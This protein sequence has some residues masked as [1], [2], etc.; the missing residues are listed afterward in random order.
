[1][2]RVS[3]SALVSVSGSIRLAGCAGA[4]IERS[5]L[6]GLVMLAV[7][8]VMCLAAN[9]YL[10]VTHVDAPGLPRYG[11]T[12]AIHNPF[13]WMFVC[14]FGQAVSHAAEPHLPPRVNGTTEW[15]PLADFIKG[16]TTYGSSR[17]P[18]FERGVRLLAQVFFGTFDEWLA[19]PRLPPVYVLESMWALGYQPA[20]RREIRE[21]SRKC[22]ESG[23]PALDYIGIGG[24]TLMR[25][26]RD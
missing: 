5:Y 24:G 17:L 12:A 20:R 8:V 9:A 19:A 2:P 13:V 1:M 22:L 6:W 10:A 14:A 16:T 7:V 15:V 25:A 11:A 23:N 26:S 4:R 18:A 3:T 21:L